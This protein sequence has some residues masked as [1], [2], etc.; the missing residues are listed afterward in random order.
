[1]SKKPQSHPCPR[2]ERVALR[3]VARPTGERPFRG[4]AYRDVS[5]HALTLHTGRWW[6]K[7][8]LKGHTLS[9]PILQRATQ[10]PSGKS[11]RPEGPRAPSPSPLFTMGHIHKHFIPDN[12]QI[13]APYL[14]I[15]NIRKY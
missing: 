14:I 7:T 15:G 2:V 10:C 11:A 12:L 3:H 6:E 8:F 5:A 13:I 9:A 1:M 4:V